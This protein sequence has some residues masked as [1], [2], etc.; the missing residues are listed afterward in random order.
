MTDPTTELV[1]VQVPLGHA[2]EDA[3]T[4]L[5]VDARLDRE[6]GETLSSLLAGLN[7]TGERLPPSYLFPHG[8][9]IGTCADA[10]RWLL[11]QIHHARADDGGRS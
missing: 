7:E 8:K 5:H 11:Q 4:P 1:R 9:P 6:M 3:R 10:L 2:G